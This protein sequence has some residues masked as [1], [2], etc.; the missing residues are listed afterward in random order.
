MG[1]VRSAG[2]EWVWVMEVMEVCESV[3]VVEEVVVEVVVDEDVVLSNE[4][5]EREG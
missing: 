4:M 5:R 3:R 2:R 1:R